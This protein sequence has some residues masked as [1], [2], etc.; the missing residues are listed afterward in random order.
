MKKLILL[1]ITISLFSCATKVSS[2]YQCMHGCERGH[3][4]GARR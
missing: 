4:T 3:K 2:D 1:L